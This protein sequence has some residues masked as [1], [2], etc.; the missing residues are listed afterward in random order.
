MVVSMPM[1]EKLLK[2]LTA[3]AHQF[4]KNYHKVMTRGSWN[5]DFVFPVANANNLDRSSHVKNA[6]ILL[7]GE[8]T[9]PDSERNDGSMTRL[10]KGRTTIVIAHRLTVSDSYHVCPQQGQVAEFGHTQAT[11]S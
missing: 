9:S 11:G 3:A 7:L 8:A 1:R 6:P 10:M 4:I 5:A 2:Q